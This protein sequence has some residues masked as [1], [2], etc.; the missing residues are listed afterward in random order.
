MAPLGLALPTL[1]SASNTSVARA[2]DGVVDIAAANL[3]FPHQL[4]HPVPGRLRKL[5]FPQG[6]PTTPPLA[7]PTPGAVGEALYVSPTGDD[8]NPGISPSAPLRTLAAATSRVRPGMTVNL[9]GGTYAEQLITRIAGAEGQEITYQ[10]YN[11]TATLDGAGLGWPKA[12]DQNQALVKL[13]HSYSHI[14]GL[15][16]INSNDSGVVLDADHLTVEQCEIAEIQ[17]HG[18]GTRTTRQTGIPGLAGSNIHDINLIANNLYHCTLA[19]PG[20]GQ[21]IGLIAD[22]FSVSQNDVHD[23]MDIGINVCL[24]ASNGEVME[25]SVHGNLLGAGINLAGVSNI[26]IDRNKVN[27]NKNG[28]GVSSEDTRYKCQ[29]IQIYNNLI[30]DQTGIGCFIWDNGAPAGSAGSQN[31][32]LAHNTLVNNAV[33]FFF[34]GSSN[35]AEVMNNLAVGDACSD[36]STASNIRLHDNVW[37]TAE[38]GFN[39]IAH[40]DFRLDNSSEAIDKGAAEATWLDEKGITVTIDTD[41]AGAPR[42]SRAAP[43]AGAYEMP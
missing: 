39:D 29:N 18:I 28:I 17:R 15:K 26:R 42:V 27:G 19:G 10:S 2:I 8:A 30:F 12:G 37:L 40:R 6:P 34:S 33:A 1:P 4:P 14:K 11:G 7:T 36:S 24:G 22:G 41:F 38:S 21:A 5:L 23:N 31:V 25:N 13:D 20:S 3:G 32:L 35:T 16:V 43:D 9:A